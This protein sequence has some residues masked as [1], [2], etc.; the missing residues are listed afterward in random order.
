[1]A[2]P[3][4]FEIKKLKKHADPRGWLVEFLKQSEIT[5]KIQQIYIVSLEPGA[6]R[7]NHYHQKRIEWFFVIGDDIRIH[8]QDI[9]TKE[10][11]IIDIRPDNPL[12]I[13]I[14]PSTAHAVANKGKNVAYLISAQNN[15][16]DS[17]APD[18]FEYKLL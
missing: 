7:G 3:M 18:T 8:L 5:E 13:S 4:N 9:K 6:I 10:T 11:K 16:Y 17:N 12:R 15:I 2:G 1:M 14:F